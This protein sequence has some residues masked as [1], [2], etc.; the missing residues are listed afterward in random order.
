[1]KMRFKYSSGRNQ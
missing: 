1:M